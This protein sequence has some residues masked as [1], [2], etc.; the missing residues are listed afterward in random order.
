MTDR[1]LLAEGRELLAAATPGPW[2]FG[3]HCHI[4]KGCR[5]LCCHDPATVWYITNMLGCEDVPVPEGADQ[6]RCDDLGHT[7][8]D[9]ELIVWTRNNLAGVLDELESLRTRARDA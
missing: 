5:C 9:A 4:E 3:P 1:D 8:N 7:Y 2:D 6:E